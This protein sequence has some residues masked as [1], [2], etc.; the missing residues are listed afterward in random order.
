[1]NKPIVVVGSINLDLAV[2]A[3]R[4]PCPGETILGTDF[5]VFPGGKG[6]NQ[7]AASA[8]LGYPT[9]MIGH[10]GDDRFA[11]TLQDALSSAGVHAHAVTRVPGPSGVAVIVAAESGENS[12]VVAPGANQC[13]TPRDL[14]AFAP[15][16]ES[17]AVVLTQLEIPP[18]TTEALARL[19]SRAGIPLILDPAPARALP[20]H[21]LAAVEWITP[22]ESEAQF[23]SGRTAVPRCHAELCELSECLLTLGPRNVLLKLGERGAFLAAQDGSRIMIPPYPVVPLDTTAAGDAFNAGFAV[24]L[25]RG[26]CAPEAAQFA[27]AVAAISVTRLGAVP[28]LPTQDEVAAFIAEHSAIPQE[29]T[30]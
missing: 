17:A 25:A 22:N 14:D 6:A 26:S 20:S 29:T 27:S 3:P 23:L 13:L 15:L 24:A 4:I 18:E 21:V 19:T 8:R 11:D 2:R 10:L 16:I 9:F 1:M 5:G 30:L 28:S 12:I 7:A